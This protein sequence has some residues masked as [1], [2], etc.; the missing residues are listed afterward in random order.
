MARWST[1]APDPTR[2]PSSIVQPSRWALW[3]ITQSAPTDVC[4][5]G[6]VC[7]TVPSWMEVRAPDEMAPSSA[8]STALGHTEAS[9]PSVTAPMITA[10][11]CT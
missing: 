4:Q 6:V 7:T 5:I 3:P 1:T 10:S 9:A 8:R 2:L 11:G